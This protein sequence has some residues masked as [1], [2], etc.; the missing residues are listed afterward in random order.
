[1]G[2]LVA[3]QILEWLSGNKVFR[4]WNTELGVFL[5]AISVCFGMIWLSRTAGI[6]KFTCGMT[7]LGA[8]VGVI[9]FFLA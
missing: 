4:N 7:L 9:L 5:F 8:V 3:Y 2:G 6:A 1:L